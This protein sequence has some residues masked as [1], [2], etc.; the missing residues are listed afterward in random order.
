M[1]AYMRLQWWPAGSW[2]SLCHSMRN[3]RTWISLCRRT[4]R[5]CRVLCSFP[6]QRI[7]H[8]SGDRRIRTRY[9]PRFGRRCTWSTLLMHVRRDSED[10]P[11]DFSPRTNSAAPPGILA[12]RCLIG[13]IRLDRMSEA[14]VSTTP[15]AVHRHHLKQIQ[16]MR[17]RAPNNTCINKTR[18]DVK[19][20]HI[21]VYWL[22]SM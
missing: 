12:S 16:E 9:S 13:A 5:P 14:S 21:C 3:I 20:L 10:S 2:C 8:H 15:P 11:A 1:S 4:P 7:A 22:F 19:M 18:I 6:P 17:K